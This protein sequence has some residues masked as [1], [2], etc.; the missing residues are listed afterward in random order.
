[1]TFEE[2]QTLTEKQDYVLFGGAKY[3]VACLYPEGS[4]LHKTFIGIYDEPPSFHIDNVL[5]ESCQ[6]IKVEP[7][8]I[9]NLTNKCGFFT[10]DTQL[11]GGCGCNHK[12]QTEWDMEN[13]KKQ[14]KCYTHSCPIAWTMEK[15]DWE[16]LGKDPTFYT[17]GEWLVKF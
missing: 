3:R 13:G 9:H 14:G 11:N 2:S 10:S 6:L 7:I 8:H 12:N 15:E 5:I 1:M 4:G 17:E 16:D